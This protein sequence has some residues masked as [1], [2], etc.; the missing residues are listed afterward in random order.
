MGLFKSRIKSIGITA[1]FLVML[2]LG[3]TNEDRVSSL[4]SI[5]YVQAIGV[6]KAKDNNLSFTLQFFQGMG[7][8]SETQVDTTSA[9]SKS[10]TAEA[11]SYA[12]AKRKI[13][14]YTGRSIFTGQ[15]M[16][17][18]LG[19]S[20]SAK[21]IYEIL[22][23]FSSDKDIPL[24]ARVVL[25]KQTAKEI[26]SVELTSG[27]T[28]A[29]NFDEIIEQSIKTGTTV[30]C[31][32]SAVLQERSSGAVIMPL[33]KSVVTE[34]AET[35]NMEKQM[36]GEKAKEKPEPDSIRVC[37]DKSAVCINKNGNRTELTPRQCQI[38]DILKG[39]KHY[40]EVIIGDKPLQSCVFL[41]NITSKCKYEGKKAKFKVSFE[42]SNV[43]EINDVSPE[44]VNKMLCDEIGSM[45]GEIFSLIKSE[46]T[47]AL[48][49]LMIIRKSEFGDFSEIIKDNTKLSDLDFELEVSPHYT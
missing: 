38:I 25:T 4:D 45:A 34:N 37:E 5:S 8:G 28:S 33:V 26:L 32:L 13:E 22:D 44:E 48:E 29:E 47:D 43:G 24:S 10:Y 16:I 7:S 11:N 31:K 2:F 21:D 6:D 40:S 30:C 42:I 3:A 17:I 27:V 35:Q 14:G 18:A 49:L 41:N 19:D 36:N 39:C 15:T 20:L 12:A 46:Q 9:N 23:T 1:V